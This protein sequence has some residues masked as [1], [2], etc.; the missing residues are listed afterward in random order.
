MVMDVLAPLAR[1]TGYFVRINHKVST[2]EAANNRQGDVEPLMNFD[3]DGYNNFPIDVSICCYHISNSTVNNG[4]LNGKMHTNDYLQV[5]VG[6]TG[7]T[8]RSILLLVRRSH[9]AFWP[10]IGCPGQLGTR[11]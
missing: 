1:N 7:G 10:P 3:L 8:K 6:V 9:Q 5:R 4:H 2:T 11:S